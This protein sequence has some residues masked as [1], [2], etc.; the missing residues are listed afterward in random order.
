VM[1]SI[2][3]GKVLS[4]LRLKRAHADFFLTARHPTRLDRPPKYVS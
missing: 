4:L 2:G 1:P 3:A